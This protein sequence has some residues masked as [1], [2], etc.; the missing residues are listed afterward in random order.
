LR[1]IWDRF[2]QEKN[3]VKTGVK[4]T[5]L[6]MAITKLICDAM[7]AEVKAES[8]LG[9]GSVFTVTLHSPIS[10]ES[11][12]PQI[13]TVA[14][15]EKHDEVLDRPMKLLVAEDNELNAELLVEIL[16]SEGF[17]V[18]YAQNGKVAVE[19]FQ[20][21]QPG[22][23]DAVLMDMQMPIMDGCEAAS[24][25][26]RLDRTDAKTVTI[27]ACTANSFQEDREHAIA[28]GMNDFIT[29]PI[30]V[31]VLLKKLEETGKHAL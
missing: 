16:E 13:E 28:S 23:I 26:R 4:S 11:E 25:I 27:F 7:G 1:H 9:K 18:L 31:K 15:E 21:S 17:Q 30:D 12:C 24:E 14:R 20:E 6:G 3:N 19:E 29:K 8:E 2:S 5:G 22:D 10:Q